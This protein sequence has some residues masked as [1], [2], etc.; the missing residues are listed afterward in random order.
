[1]A[2]SRVKQERVAL[3]QPNWLRQSASTVSSVVHSAPNA[4]DFRS[5][6][7]IRLMLPGEMGVR[8]LPVAERA[9]DVSGSKA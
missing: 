5:T 9:G 1:M 2:T 6:Q 4:A 7:A 3:R 8:R